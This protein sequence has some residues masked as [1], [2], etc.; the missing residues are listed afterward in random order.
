MG[1]M[2]SVKQWAERYGRDGSYARRLINAGRLPAVRVG[3]Q[4]AID[5]DTLPPPDARVKSGKYKDWRK[6]PA[7]EPEQ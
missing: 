3:N 7:G 5:S 6:K 1:E 2:L 4:W